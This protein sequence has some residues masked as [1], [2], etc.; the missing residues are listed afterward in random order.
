MCYYCVLHYS[1]ARCQVYWLL[2]AGAWWTWSCLRS[3]KWKNTSTPT[4]RTAVAPATGHIPMIAM[5]K[6]RTG[7]KYETI[8][9][10][11]ITDLYLGTLP[12]YPSRGPAPP[13]SHVASKMGFRTN[14][15]IA[16]PRCLFHVHNNTFMRTR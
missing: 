1:S 16:Q 8:E 7:I 5:K 11:K 13:I 3:D 15:S 2:Y 6:K 10:N 12:W 9:Q 14:A 4:P